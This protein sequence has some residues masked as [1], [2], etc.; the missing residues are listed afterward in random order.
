[1]KM[2]DRCRDP[3]YTKAH[4]PEHRVPDGSPMNIR[5]WP[6]LR[7]YPSPE[8]LAKPPKDT[9]PRCPRC[10]ERLEDPSYLAPYCWHELLAT[11]R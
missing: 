2:T 5:D 11:L 4:R 9:R 6:L 7:Q 8:P 1:M 10:G 3:H